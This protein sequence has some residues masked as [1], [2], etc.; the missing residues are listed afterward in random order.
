MIKFELSMENNNQNTTIINKPDSIKLNKR[1]D[2][3]YEGFF[4]YIVQN[5]KKVLIIV[6]CSIFYSFGQ[7]HFMMKAGSV[8][9][10]VEAISVSMAYILTVLK[11]Y[12][13]ILYLALNIPLIVFYW[14]KIK[15]SFIVTTLI[16]LFFNALFGFIFGVQPVEE[17]ISQKVIVIME[18]GWVVQA[19][20][21]G[22]T[23]YVNAGWPVF[24][25]VILAVACCSPSSAIVWK[26][27]AS[28]GGTDL[29]A[30]Y[31]S[32]KY[33]KP[34]GSFLI[35]VGTLMA[36][37][38]ILFL[39]LSKKFMP[40]NISL[41]INGFDNI[42][43]CQTFGTYLYIL[44]NG[45]VINLIYPKYQ[46]VRLKIDTRN[47]KELTDFFKSINFWHPYKIVESISGYNKKTIYSIE[48]VVL[49]LESDDIAK[50]I[51]DYVPDAWISV[52]PIS[53]IYG[54]FDYSKI[55]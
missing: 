10:G 7:V 22:T 51:K 55:D 47:L 41:N 38:G 48:S 53:K 19:A 49:L 40:A 17:F 35:L 44:L 45:F 43:G 29:I 21:N 23:N 32:Y 33:K 26:L 9:D 24:V 16:F 39:Y 36:T 52:A 42:L 54:R 50:K 5:W 18:D 37:M 1:F 2:T 34:V 6:V 25:Y 20:N 3:N 46:K 14:R 30:Y 8:L 4:K 31:I 13:T 28:T 27:G 11:P 15:R 12:L